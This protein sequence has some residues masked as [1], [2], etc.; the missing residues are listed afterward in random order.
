[1]GSNILILLHSL[2]TDYF[3]FVCLCVYVRRVNGI[4]MYVLVCFLK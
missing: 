1:M 3:M 4:C 2:V